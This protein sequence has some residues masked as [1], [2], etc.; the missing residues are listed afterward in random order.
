MR[1]LFSRVWRPKISIVVVFFNMRREA[2]RTLFA[3]TTTYQRDVDEADYE[4]IVV[5]SNSSEPLDENWVES[6]QAN[7]HYQYVKSNVPTPN[8]AMNWGI[9]HARGSHIVCVIDGARIPSPGII[10]KMLQ[11]QHSSSSV[12]AMTLGMHIG[13]KPQHYAVIDGYCQSVEDKIIDGIE[14]KNDG[15]QLFSVSSLA[16]SSRGGFFNPIAE[17][18]CFMAP[19]AALTAM[20]GFDERFVSPGG[21][22]I[23]LHVHN[24]LIEHPKLNPVMLLGEAT[25]HQ[26]HGGVATNTP[27]HLSP[28]K[29]FS[30]EYSR[31]LG[32]PFHK[33]WKNPGYI[34][35]MHPL[36]KQFLCVDES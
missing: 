10:A 11:A 25:F 21:G 27:V 28:F 8:K 5:D 19:K 26:F 6:L 23:N 32:E 2:A 12:Y 20:G 9:D 16:G 14:W 4:V 35:T 18:N 31:I 22:L 30:E 3:F 17:S 34:G 1:K 36:A 15:Y 7:F 24:Q 33:A 13:P 29:K